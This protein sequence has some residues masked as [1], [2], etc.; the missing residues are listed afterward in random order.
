MFFIKCS[1]ILSLIATS[2][3]SLARGQEVG[4]KYNYEPSPYHYEYMVHDDK[5]YLDFGA[6]EEGDFH[7]QYHVQLPDGRLQQSA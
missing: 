6:K 4:Y 5:E 7:G 3:L 1:V 2:S